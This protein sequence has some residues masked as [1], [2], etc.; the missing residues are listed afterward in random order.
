MTPDLAR[1]MMD[2]VIGLW[3][4]YGA[5]FLRVGTAMLVLP[6]FGEAAIP[7]RVRLAASLAFSAAIAPAVD[8]MPQDVSVWRLAAE[9]VTGLAFGLV[10]RLFVLVLNIAGAIIAQSTSLAQMF[11]GAAGEPQPAAGHLLTMGGIALAFAMGLHLSLAEALIASYAAIPQGA[12][13]AAGDIRGWGVAEVA[14]AFAMALSLSMPFVIA[15]LIYNV[16]LGAIN[17]AM[18]QLMVSMI[19]APALTL[20]GLAMLVLA[21]PAGLSL[22]H[23]GLVALLADPFAGAR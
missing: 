1:T 5:V 18:P 7:V 8:P 10:L 11:G 6:G 20:G 22:W 12:L 2:Q 19:G 9:P 23:Q 16:A 4:L 21:V 14:R 3:M 15:A 13:P 17:R